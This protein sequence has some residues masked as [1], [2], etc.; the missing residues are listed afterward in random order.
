[1]K[2]HNL[3]KVVM[4]AMAVVVVL[5]WILPITYYSGGVLEEPISQ[6]GIFE[7]MSYVGIAIQYFSHIGIYV[8]AVGGLYGVLHKVSGYRNLLD[9]IAKGFKD[10][11]WIFMS[12]VVVLFAVL[13]AMAGLSLPLMVLFP[14]VISVILLMGYDKI[15]AAM[16]T[17]G[18]TVIGLIGSV[19]STNNTYGIDVVIGSLPDNAVVEKLLLLFVGVALLIFNVV[20][21]SKKHK[22]TK[23][24]ESSDYIPE[25][26]NKKAKSWPIV[27]VMDVVLLVLVASFISWDL[28]EITFF[29]DLLANVNKFK[30]FDI[31]VFEAV[32]G[33]ASPF[34]TWTLV[35]ATVLLVLASWLIS[36]VYKIKFNDY[37]TYFMNGAKRALKAAV[38]VT[39]IYV[40]LVAVTYI[41]TILTMV[42]PILDATS[43]LNVFTMAI[44]AFIAC[45]LSVELYYGATAIL[46]YVTGSLFTALAAE[47]ITLLSLIWQSM[48]GVAMLV[49]PTSVVLIATLAYLHVPYQNWLKA[50][51]KL[52]L[53]LVVVLLIIFTIMTLI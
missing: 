38:L 29:E 24:V 20:T 33:L 53:E 13:S 28:F 4:I 23:A 34:G 50:I 44:V 26:I 47:E 6:I 52:L 41:P 9:K 35:E 27:V 40:V 46:P 14:F 25:S 12:I 32:F 10:R 39:L 15:T 5:S 1:M 17:A 49:A 42:K 8:L 51:W 31:P 2:K 3:F 18:S 43:G 11:E 45:A 7:L 30:I 48:Y 21:Y 19:F 37:V 16:V 22:T 36:F